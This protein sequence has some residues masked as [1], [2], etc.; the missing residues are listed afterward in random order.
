[1]IT[2]LTDFGIRDGG[3]A[4]MKGVIWSI[5]PDVKITDLS[6]TVGPQNIQEAAVILRRVVPYFPAGAIHIAVVDPGVGTARR[7]IAARLG[8]HYFVGPDNGLFTPILEQAE[9]LDRPVQV[10]ELNNPQYWL[11]A[12]SHVFH[13]RDIFAPTGAHLATGVP[14]AALGAAIHDPIRLPLPQPEPTATGL[15]GEV[16]QIDDFGNIA[17]NIFREHLAGLALSDVRVHLGDTII[18]GMA[19]TFGDCPAGALIALYGT[20]HDLIVS[21]VNGNAAA[22]LQVEVGHVVEVIKRN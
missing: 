4:A 22:R 9:R 14:L 18:E 2:L 11:P 1:L 16:I 12:V 21:V 7:P 5:A 13:G 19:R 15:R 10:V 17:T 6:H 20:D 8:D 3:V